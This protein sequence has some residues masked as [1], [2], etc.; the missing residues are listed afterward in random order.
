[1]LNNL[2]YSQEIVCIELKSKY[3]IENS[4][5]FKELILGTLG[6]LGTLSTLKNANHIRVISHKNF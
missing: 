5:K 3:T 4:Q 2:L 6:T 1:M